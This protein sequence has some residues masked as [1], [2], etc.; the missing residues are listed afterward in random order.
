MNARG[1]VPRSRRRAQRAP[2]GRRRPSAPRGLEDF[3]ILP[4]VPERC[5]AEGGRLCAGRRD[6]SARRRARPAAARL[7]KPCTL[8][9]GV[10]P[11][12]E[13]RVC[14]HDD[15]DAVLVP[16][17]GA[18]PAA[19]QPPRTDWS[20]RHGRRSLARRRGRTPRGLSGDNSGRLRLRRAA[21]ERARRPSAL[22]GRSGR[23]DSGVIK[24]TGTYDR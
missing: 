21:P 13:I 24:V 2:V 18:G 7:S 16:E 11:L 8:A 17:A 1:R 14:Y 15:A 9:F 23:L 3:E 5:T 19:R 12:D 22:A 20:E 6:Q 10:L 4:G